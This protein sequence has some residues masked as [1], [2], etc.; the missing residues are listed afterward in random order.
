VV[1]PSPEV[2]VVVAPVEAQPVVEPQESL[3]RHESAGKGELVVEPVESVADPLP[4]EPTPVTPA[5]VAPAAP[6]SPKAT[7]PSEVKQADDPVVELKSDPSDQILSAVLQ[8]RGKWQGFRPKQVVLRAGT[9]FI[10]PLPQV[11]LANMCM[12]LCS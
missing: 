2:A 9:V 5:S 11:G 4:V 1:V 3:S 6:E 7:E 10:S 8:K 12:L